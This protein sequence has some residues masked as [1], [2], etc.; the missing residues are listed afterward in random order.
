MNVEDSKDKVLERFLKALEK[1]IKTKSYC[2]I[3]LQIEHG[4]L[5]LFRVTESFK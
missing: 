1:K 2:E 3:V 5:R 4:Q